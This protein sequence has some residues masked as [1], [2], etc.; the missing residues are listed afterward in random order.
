MFPERNAC[1]L[2]CLAL[3]GLAGCASEQIVL[4]PDADGKVGAL[5]VTRD[6]GGEVR[7]DQ[8]YGTARVEAGG[9]QFRQSTAAEVN[10]RYRTTIAATPAGA[11]SYL[12]YFVIDKVTLLPESQASFNTILSDFQGRPSAEVILIGHTDKSGSAK[13]NEELSQRRANAIRSQLIAGGVSPA[14]IETAWRGDREPLPET[15]GKTYDQRNRR[16]EVK[17]R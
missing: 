2:L 7:L 17:V 13:Y 9:I 16:V 5:V 3:L 12:L 4:L 15:T 14:K 11:R 8:S 6:K 1:R 10:E